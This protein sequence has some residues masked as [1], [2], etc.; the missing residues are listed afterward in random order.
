ML[1]HNA[2]PMPSKA[3]SLTSTYDSNMSSW[4]CYFHFLLFFLSFQ[5]LFSVFKFFC[6]FFSLSFIVV[7]FIV[8]LCLTIVLFHSTCHCMLLQRACTPSANFQTKN[9]K[10]KNASANT[11]ECRSEKEREKQRKLSLSLKC[12]T[13]VTFLMKRVY[14]VVV[15]FDCAMFTPQRKIFSRISFYVYCR[16]RCRTCAF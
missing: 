11:N 4:K 1:I 7:V 9:L 12:N 8:G 2:L 15:A 5:F 6:P 16:C 13:F 10:I 3:S 14:K